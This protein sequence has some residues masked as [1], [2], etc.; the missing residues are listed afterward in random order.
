MP[1]V[2]IGVGHGGSDVGASA[3]GLV[4][5]I[6]TLNTS[7][8]CKSILE[9]HGVQ[10]GISRSCDE[11]DTIS[12]EVQE[13][14]SYKP[15][16]AV[17]IHYNAGGGDGLE[18][19]RYRGGGE[20]LKAAQK[21]ETRL[22]QAGQNSRGIKVKLGNDGLDYYMWIRET[23]APAIL[24]E[25]GFLDNS[26]DNQ[27]F[28]TPEKQKELGKAIAY[29]ILDYF[30]IRINISTSTVNQNSN[31]LYRVQI[32]AFS[33]KSNAD[34]LSKELTNK[35]YSNIVKLDGNLYK[36][37]VGAF[38]NRSNAEKLANELKAKGY[39]TLIKIK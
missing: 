29:G 21:V 24:I 34:N 26:T 33:K 15:N 31:N 8:A 39:N 1:K 22:V 16:I 32:G 38:A 23:K 7:L 20:S 13:C 10:V 36:V 2:F 14:N 28:N 9:Q 37:Q 19:Y 30:G 5:K 11:E 18:I 3:Y 12:Q 35:G 17:E 27:L 4:E 25:V 6:L